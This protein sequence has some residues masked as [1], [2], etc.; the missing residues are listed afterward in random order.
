MSILTT[1]PIHT[2][3]DIQIKL[4]GNANKEESGSSSIKSGQNSPTKKVAPLT[5]ETAVELK[6][7][8]QETVIPYPQVEDS[9]RM[10]REQHSPSPLISNIR[11]EILASRRR[12]ANIQR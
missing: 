3:I 9:S 10:I 12:A 5:L 7:D 8:L 2:K 1:A 11:E 6:Y 4:E